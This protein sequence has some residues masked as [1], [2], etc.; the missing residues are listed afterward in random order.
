[1]HYFSPQSREALQSVPGTA[2][3]GDFGHRGKASLTKEILELGETS[4]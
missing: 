1:M 3:S 4:V 2:H